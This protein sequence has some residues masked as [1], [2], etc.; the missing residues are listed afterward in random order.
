M[1]RDGKGWEGHEGGGDAKGM[2]VWGL[3]GHGKRLDNG[4]KRS[5]NCIILVPI[6]SS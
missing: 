5:Q 4:E 1:V 6:N 3:D 2:M